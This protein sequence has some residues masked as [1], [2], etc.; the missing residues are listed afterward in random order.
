MQT[1]KKIID[2]GRKLPFVN[3]SLFQIG[4]DMR[5]A[6]DR[7]IMRHSRLPDRPIMDTKAFPWIARL[8]SCWPVIR[9]EALRIRGEDIPSLGEI[10]PDHG[11]IAADPRWKS[12]FLE[13]YGYQRTENRER[14]PIT[15][16]LIDQIPDLV[17]AC[18]SVL[19]AGGHIPRHYG[20][21]KGMLTYHLP[22]RVPEEREKCHINI[23]GAD[24]LHVV[25]WEEGRSLL[26]DDMYN[27]EVWNDTDEDRYLLLIQVQRPCSAPANWLQKLFLF[28]VRHSRFVQ[29]IKRQLD[30]MRPQKS[31]VA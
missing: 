16:A 30:R 5:P 15:S 26:F 2:T 18:F 1:G 7:F 6:I 11:R 21:T 29:D 31:S 23:E 9:D 27:H 13:G 17:T 22:L 12:F 3:K 14:A 8:E 20:M 25:A 19:E 28:C 4:K 24:R 10:S